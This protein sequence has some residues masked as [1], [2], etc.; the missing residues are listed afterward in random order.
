MAQNGR[1]AMDSNP[2]D[3]QLLAAF[4]DGDRAA[5][6]QLAGRY[7]PMLLGLAAGLLGGSSSMACDAVQETWMRVIRHGHSF[8]GRSGLKTWLYRIAIN[9]CRD[10]ATKESRQPKRE[11]P[12]ELGGGGEEPQQK[13]AARERNDALR[14][15]VGWLAPAQREILLLCY[16][17]AMTHAQAAEILEIPVGTL[18]SRLHAALGEL[19]E[20]IERKATP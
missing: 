8:N 3:E 12:Q 2:T 17:E 9:R 6:G 19:R 13:L 7:E 16:H 1:S 10:M 5:L 18:K 14:E 15:A 4:L 11:A 20:R